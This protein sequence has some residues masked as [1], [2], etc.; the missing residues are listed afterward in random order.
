MKLYIA[1][2]GVNTTH[3]SPKKGGC[4]S[5]I[6]PNGTF[7]FI[8]IPEDKRDCRYTSNT[9]STI[10]C[11]NNPEL[12]LTLSHYID[13]EKYHN[14]AVHNDPEFKTYT[15]GDI[16]TPRAS[17]LSEIEPNDVLLFLARLYKF[18]EGV[19]TDNGDLY[20]IGCFTIEENKIFDNW[21]ID[22]HSKELVKWREN[23]HFIKFEKGK[24]ETFR[25]L[26]GV[27]NRSCRFKS[28]LRTD[29]KVQELIYNREYDENKDIFISNKDNEAVNNKKEEEIKKSSFPSKTRTIQAHLNSEIPTES[30]CIRKLLEE[31]KKRCF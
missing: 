2:V 5:P 16:M 23:A 8:P 22:I 20:F 21:R 7:E 1:N 27:S 10:K 14:Y 28:A 13:E 24:M 11:Y 9:Y 26:K 4:K 18:K 6:F 19:F 3:A 25:I 31:I 12:T 30:E 17:N 29:I 15:Y